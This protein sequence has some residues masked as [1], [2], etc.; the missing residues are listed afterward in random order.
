M[1]RLK[2]TFMPYAL[3]V[4]L[5]MGALVG[6][7]P[8]RAGRAV[9]EVPVGS[10]PSCGSWHVV[11]SPNPGDFRDLSGVAAI[12]PRDIWAV[13]PGGQYRMET[14][15]ALIEH[16]D[17]TQ[18]RVVRNP[19]IGA[20]D[21]LRAVAHIPGTNRL[22]AVGYYGISS[23]APYDLT[24]IEQWNGTVWR[25][26][27]SPNPGTISN[28]LLGVAAISANDAWAV[29]MYSNNFYGYSRMFTA[30][31]D[32]TSWRVVPS[33][34]PPGSIGSLLYSVTAVATNDV[35]AVGI[36]QNSNN[37]TQSLFEHWDG[38]RWRIVPGPSVNRSSGEL[39]SIT[40]VSRDDIWAVGS[41]YDQYNVRNI[42]LIERWN[43]MSW[44]VVPSPNLG[45]YSD[46][47]I[48]VAAVSAND[49]W[50]VGM[51]FNTDNST[52]TLTEHWNGASWSVVPSPNPGLY[53]GLNGVAAVPGT[54]TGVVAVGSYSSNS[55]IPQVQTLTMY[56]C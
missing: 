38:T 33:P 29:G 39:I 22:W 21:I 55:P 49:V 25:V 41:S 31:W 19:S 12:S 7:G 15:G 28:A 4:V 30:H 17:G 53:N 43:G 47:L 46:Y 14:G 36:S 10:A 54:A 51:Y 6:A 16:W 13:G 20:A 35:W 44:V 11:A 1:Y 48:G 9:Q 26:V 24:L 52:Q 27:P 32:G 3:I 2:L 8:A 18:W 5:T 56:Y 23:I 50:T 37:Q 40:A 42:T 34:I 45:I